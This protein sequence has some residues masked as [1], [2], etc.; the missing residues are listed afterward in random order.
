MSCCLLASRSDV[1]VLSCKAHGGRCRFEDHSA[2]IPVRPD[3]GEQESNDKQCFLGLELLFLFPIISDTMNTLVSE[4]LKWDDPIK[5]NSQCQ[6]GCKLG[7]LSDDLMRE[8]NWKWDVDLG[9]IIYQQKCPDK[10]LS[11]L[12]NTVSKAR[13]VIQVHYCYC[14]WFLVNYLLSENITEKH[15]ALFKPG[16]VS[17]Y[18][19]N[20]FFCYICF[21][22]VALSVDSLVYVALL[23]HPENTSISWK[24][25]IISKMCMCAW[26]STERGEN[27]WREQWWL[28]LLKQLFCL[29]SLLFWTLI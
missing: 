2:I 8:F 7:L 4:V 12:P 23:M 24:E 9:L 29:P 1:N 21:L 13:K 16:F 27:I 14:Q 15:K 6:Q 22:P 25:N 18:S 5:T 19:I 3:S 26:V 17:L 10:L 20:T 28:M 11:M